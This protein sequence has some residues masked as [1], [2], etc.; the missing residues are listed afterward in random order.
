MFRTSSVAI[1]ALVLGPG[2]AGAATDRPNIVLIMADDMGRET[3]GAYGGTSYRTPNIDR[4]AQ[5]GL[6]FEHAYATP[7]CTNTRIQLMTGRYN[8]RNWLGFGLLD[9]RERTFGH[10]LQE[11]GY[12]TVIVGKWQL[13]SY[14]PPGFPGAEL[15]RGKGMRPQDAGFDEYSLW[16]TGHTETK[17]SR[18]ADP[19]IEQNGE[20]LPGTEGGYG[21][22]IWVDYLSDFMTRHQ[23]RPFF[24]YYSMALPHWP[25]VPTPASREW[26]D[27]DGRLKEDLRHA[28]DMIEYADTALGRILDKIDEL[29]LRETTLVLFYTDNGTDWRVTSRMRGRVV[30]GG[31]SY[32]TDAGTRVPL[33]ARWP[34]VTTPGAVTETLVDSTDFLPTLVEAAGGE[35]PDDI[36][37]RS[38]LPQVRGEP[39]NPRQW[40]YMH[41]DPRPGWDKDR[42]RLIR[43]ARNQRFKLYE[44]GRLFEVPADALEDR[45]LL[46]AQDTPESAGARVQLQSVLDSMKPYPIFD[47]DTMRRPEEEAGAREGLRFRDRFGVVVAEAESA[48]APPDESWRVESAIPGFTGPGYVRALRDQADGVEKGAIPFR[49][50]LNSSGSWRL[51]VRS[52]RDHP[53]EAREDDFWLRVD[54]GPWMACRLPP[55]RPVGV[56]D[57]PTTVDRPGSSA[58]ALSELKLDF[59]LRSGEGSYGKNTPVIWIAPRSANVKIDRVVLYQ[60]DREARALDPAT[61]QSDYDPW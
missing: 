32:A 25:F 3:V 4:L 55:G 47:P 16:H 15:R 40:V 12:A 57:W 58:I 1:A 7:L 20:R 17:G 39:G 28:T 5:E 23:D 24:A 61:P 42:F 33:I 8:N 54:D 53:A 2:E 22:D 29:G 38:F 31:K 48:P 30:R 13:W 9:P 19:V 43:F 18:Y 36:D 50:N 26:D 52:R 46:P 10:Y 41:H 51:G 14:D 34:G 59:H 35:T 49:T 37:G 21:P 6:R 56:W 44:D 11:A 27:P 45:P 60:A